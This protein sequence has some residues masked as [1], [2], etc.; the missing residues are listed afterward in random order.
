MSDEIFSLKTICFFKFQISR[1][2]TASF[3]GR[4]VEA[5]GWGTVEYGGP[6]SSRLL[7]VSLDVVNQTKCESS[8][9]NS[10]TSA[11]LCTYSRNKDTCSYD[12]GM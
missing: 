3:E 7:K 6:V 9:P 10:V 11:Q 12:S 8:Y 4:R 1:F 2:R 5:I